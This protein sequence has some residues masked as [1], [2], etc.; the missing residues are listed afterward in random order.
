MI[1]YATVG[2]N[3]LQ[4]AMAFYDAL[5]GSVGISR[6]LELPHL[7]GWGVSWSKPMFGVVKPFDG[8][9]ASPGNGAMIAMG[10]RTREKVRRLHS[11]AIEMGG[12]DEGAV[13]MAARPSMPPMCAI[14][15]GTSCASTASGRGRTRLAPAS[16]ARTPCVK[17]QRFHTGRILR[18]KFRVLVL[19]VRH[20]D[21][22]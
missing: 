1:G 22:Q 20:A 4:R 17:R 16:P 6:L 2:T 3:D 14:W 9:P 19:T 11:K 18:A 8:R 7:A 21:H 12:T 10:Q 15:M 13:P 5:F